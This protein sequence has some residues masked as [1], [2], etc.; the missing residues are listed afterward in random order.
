[1]RV[2]CPYRQ[3]FSISLTVA[4]VTEKVAFILSTMMMMT[5]MSSDLT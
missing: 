5:M 1:M 3:C 2:L 4:F